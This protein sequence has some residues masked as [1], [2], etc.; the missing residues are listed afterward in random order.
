MLFRFV[1]VF[2]LAL[3]KDNNVGEDRTGSDSMWVL[4]AN[5]WWNATHYHQPHNVSFFGVLH[6]LRSSLS[7]LFFIS[8]PTNNILL[9]W[10]SKRCGTEQFSNAVLQTYY[11]YFT[12]IFLHISTEIPLWRVYV[13]RSITY[14]LVCIVYVYVCAYWY[15][16]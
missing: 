10:F 7:F 2:V 14:Y 12:N 3:L 16:V 5:P 11:K 15:M 8:G 9:R 13:L 4:A 1:N 6:R